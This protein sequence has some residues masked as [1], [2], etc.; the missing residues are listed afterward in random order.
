MKNENHG[1]K[2]LGKMRIMKKGTQAGHLL[3]VEVLP[4]VLDNLVTNQHQSKGILQKGGKGNQGAFC[5]RTILVMR[6]GSCD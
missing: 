3:S 1:K 6:S 2:E 4:V 5:S